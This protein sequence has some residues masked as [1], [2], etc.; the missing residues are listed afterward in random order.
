MQALAEWALQ[1]VAV[2][3]RCD[4]DWDGRFGAWICSETIS[5]KRNSVES[6]TSQGP[7]ALN[8]SMQGLWSAHRKAKVNLN[9]QTQPT[10]APSTTAPVSAPVSGPNSGSATPAVEKNEPVEAPATLDPEPSTSSSITPA[11]EPRSGAKRKTRSSRLADDSSKRPKL[12]G[13][14]GAIAKDY[15]P[16]TTRLS[17]LGGVESCIE[18][19]LELVAMPLCH[20]EVYIHTGVQPPRGVLLH[21]PPGCGKTLLAHAIAGVSR[22]IASSRCCRLTSSRNL[23]YPL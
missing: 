5:E 7:N 4:W 20:P 6:E 21:G 9:A 8:R 18:K 12:A 10:P 11:T 22:D 1:V 3:A 13:Q 15:A 2:S 14:S 16:P 19:M 23:E 17:D